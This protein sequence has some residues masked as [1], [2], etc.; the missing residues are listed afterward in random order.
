MGISSSERPGNRR[1]RFEELVLPFM[2]SL[3]N[4]ARRWTGSAEDASDLVQETYLRAYRTFD[5]FKLGTNCK[6]WLFTI[7]RSVFVNRHVKGKHQPEAVAPEDLEKRF[8]QCLGRVDSHMK[9]IHELDL[10]WKGSEVERALMRL[11]ESFRTAVLLVDV[12]KLTYEE[13]ADVLKCPVGT[14]RS[15]LFRGRKTLFLELQS[16]AE[17]NGYVKAK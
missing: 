10:D 4:A 2:K 12:E 15:R 16:W 3:Y 5:N 8:S 9:L 17:K 6:A 11:P 14:L 13:A 7:M 1:S